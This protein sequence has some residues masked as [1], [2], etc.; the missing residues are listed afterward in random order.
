MQRFH[1]I[2]SLEPREGT[3]ISV[4]GRAPG[5]YAAP[6]TMRGPRR[7]LIVA[8]L[9]WLERGRKR[10]I[11]SRFGRRSVQGTPRPEGP[12]KDA[13][14]STRDLRR[15]LRRGLW[16]DPDKDIRDERPSA[17][18]AGGDIEWCAW[19]AGM[20]EN[21]WRAAC[22]RRAASHREHPTENAPQSTRDL[23][24]GLRWDFVARLP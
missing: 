16:Q 21:R 18:Q 20:R 12:A 3:G 5:R 4:P 22:F 11:G 14:Q 6:Q 2:N 8:A 7:A 15:D 10:I 13:P 19:P 24:R 9:G 23:R 17:E 1:I